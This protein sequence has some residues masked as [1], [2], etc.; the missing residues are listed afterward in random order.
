MLADMETIGHKP[1]ATAGGPQRNAPAL[2]AGARRAFL[3]AM[4]RSQEAG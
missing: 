2:P 1:D 4:R 3:P